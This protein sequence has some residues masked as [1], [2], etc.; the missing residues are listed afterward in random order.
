MSIPSKLTIKKRL[1]ELR[2]LVESSKDPYVSRMAQAMEH[3][4]IWAT[5][6]TV[7]WASPAN[8]A[9]ALAEILRKECKS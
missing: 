9:I 5:S 2:G 8:E 1:K 7:G 4:I 3:A 6:D